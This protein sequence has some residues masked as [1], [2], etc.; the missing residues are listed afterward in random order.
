MAL[1]RWARTPLA[2]TWVKCPWHEQGHWPRPARAVIYGCGSSLHT[3][4][5]QGVGFRIVQNH[6]WRVVEPD[7]WVGLDPPA[8][9]DDPDTGRH[10]SDTIFPK[11]YRGTY[12]DLPAYPNRAEPRARDIPFAHF[13]DVVTADR[14]A[15]FANHGLE[16]KFMWTKNT[17][18]LAIQVALWMG[19]TDIAFA[20]VDLQG[21]YA[22]PEIE[23]KW[24]LAQIKKVNQ[25]LQEE[26]RWFKWFIPEATRR[27]IRISCLSP[28]SRL[29]ELL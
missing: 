18:H 20:A 19:F 9:F 21:H 15:I 26:F 17:M 13:A 27:G 8:M 23:R 16:Q 3:A 10:L 11:V 2:S 22:F 25:L 7:L 29:M 14:D 1:W 28:Q 4:S 6:A 24:T 12:P 5:T